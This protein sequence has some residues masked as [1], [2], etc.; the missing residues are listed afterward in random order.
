MSETNEPNKPIFVEELRS[1]I[2]DFIGSYM[3]ADHLGDVRYVFDGLR[4]MVGLPPFEGYIDHWTDR[5]KMDIPL[6]EDR[7]Y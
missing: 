1:E 7:D 4:E 5:D 2:L 3:V 6:Y